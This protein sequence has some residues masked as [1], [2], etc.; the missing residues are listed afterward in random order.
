[1]IN[2]LGIKLSF[3][4]S[5]L[6]PI[7]KTILNPFSKGKSKVHSRTGHK[8]PERVCKH[9][10]THSLTLALDGGGWSMPH[11][12]RFSPRKELVLIIQEDRW[13]PGP[14]WKSAEN[15]APTRILSLDHPASSMSLH[16]LRYP[17]PHT[18]VSISY[19]IDCKHT[20]YIMVTINH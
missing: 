12:G 1:L 14:V 2:I 11:L 5:W 6:G 17:G 15:L 8:D 9:S 3:K 18:I 13:A 4:P 7:A 19:N 20:E 16:R 10:S